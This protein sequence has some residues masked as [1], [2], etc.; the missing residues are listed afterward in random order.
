MWPAILAALQLA[1]PVAV[2]FAA[3]PAARGERDGGTVVLAYPRAWRIAA[4]AQL[5]FPVLLGLVAWLRRDT[6]LPATAA[7]ELALAAF[8]FLVLWALRIEI[9]GVRH[10]L[11]RDAIV[12]GSPWARRPVSIGWNEIARVRWSDAG[13]WLVVEAADGRRVR[14]SPLLSGVGDL[15]E[16]LTK[17]EIAAEA[18]GPGVPDRLARWV[19]ALDGAKHG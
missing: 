4:T 12:R 1:V 13:Q 5:A 2:A 18:L 7:A 6:L 8:L 10:A 17:R 9:V 19:I 11:T 16:R 3:R 14:V 15:A